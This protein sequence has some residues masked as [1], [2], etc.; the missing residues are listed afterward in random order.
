MS[1]ANCC[2]LTCMQISQEASKVAWYS[3]LVKDFPQFV[4]IHKGFSIVNQA[5]VNVFL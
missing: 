4:V 1:G 3:C 5:E 2:F